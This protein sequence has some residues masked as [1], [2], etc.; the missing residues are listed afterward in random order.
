MRFPLRR[1]RRTVPKLNMTLSGVTLPEKGEY[2]MKKCKKKN[3]LTFRMVSS[4]ICYPKAAFV[5]VTHMF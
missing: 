4:Y 2:T 1:S 3:Y 5:L